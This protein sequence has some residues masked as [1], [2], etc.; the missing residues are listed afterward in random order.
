MIFIV[1]E[2]AP[3]KVTAA[4]LPVAVAPPADVWDVTELGEAT[5][6]ALPVELAV[7]SC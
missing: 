1:P 2:Y 7:L 5:L 4:V 3:S 6:G